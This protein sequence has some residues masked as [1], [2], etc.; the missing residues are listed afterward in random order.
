M[1]HT[2]RGELCR[3]SCGM[4]A[5]TLSLW[6]GSFEAIGM[7]R[8]LAS[9]TASAHKVKQADAKQADVKQAVTNDTGVI[10]TFPQNFEPPGDGRPEDTRGSGSRTGACSTTAFSSDTETSDVTSDTDRGETAEGR[11]RAIAPPDN[12][13]LTLQS[14]PTVFLNFNGDVADAVVMRVQDEAGE[15]DERVTLPV[16][17]T[18]QV[19]GFSLPDELPALEAGKNYKWTMLVACDGRV[20]PYHPIF[21]GWVQRVA[22]DEAAATVSQQPIEA[23]VEWHTSEGYWYDTVAILDA[24][25]KATPTDA[26]T[27]LLWEQLLDFVDIN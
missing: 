23:Q 11:I 25:R 16:D 17:P 21:T 20:N 7:G 2:I 15:Y 12:F 1:Q 9:D 26:T 19:Q 6:V 8:A 10:F 14:H 27:S 24:A 4:F 13:G 5:A 18:H 22:V 3:V